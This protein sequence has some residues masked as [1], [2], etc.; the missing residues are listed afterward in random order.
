MS[1]TK[2]T[3]GPWKWQKAGEDDQPYLAPDILLVAYDGG[4]P[5][6]VDP[7]DAANAHLIAAAPELYDALEAA[8]AQWDDTCGRILD[9]SNPHW[10]N[11]ARAALAKARGAT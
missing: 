7:S 5:D 4:G 3:P 10:S 2:F 11:T 1:E 9:A 6:G 8:L